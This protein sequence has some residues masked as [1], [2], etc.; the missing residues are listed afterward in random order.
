MAAAAIG[1]TE[2]SVDR[3]IRDGRL[4]AIK[5]GGRIFIDR[6]SLEALI[7]SSDFGDAA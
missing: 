3:G 7:T 2:R 5:L 1:C 6:A 4:K